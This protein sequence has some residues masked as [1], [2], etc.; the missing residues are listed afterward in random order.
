MLPSAVVEHMMRAEN[1]AWLRPH[2][3]G[4]VDA[5]A[6][7]QQEQHPEVYAARRVEVCVP[8]TGL[9]L[10]NLNYYIG[11]A[12]LFT[13][14]TLYGNLII[15]MFSILYSTTLMTTISAFSSTW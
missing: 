9:L 7:P 12:L 14:Y 8:L 3:S 2:V 5:N 11:E 15:Y 4:P 6:K 10:R 1:E 13:I